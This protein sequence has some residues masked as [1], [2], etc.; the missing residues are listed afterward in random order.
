LPEEEAIKYFR[1]LLSAVGYC[2]Q[3]NI[4][5]RDLKPENI[6]LTKDYDVK[7]ADFGMA[8][9]QQTPDHRLQT[10][11][12]SPHYAAPEVIKGVAY[13][14]DKIDTWSMGV[15]LYAS[16]S[17]HLP[18]DNPDLAKLLATIQKGYYRMDSAFGP[19]ATDLIRRILQVDP[20]DRLNI[21]Q[22]W[23]HPLIRKY[24]HL[25]NFGGGIILKSPTVR[26]CGR[27]VIR[28]SDINMELLRHMRSLWH[29]FEE[30]DIIKLL[31]DDK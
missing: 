17:G 12:G 3:F 26:D 14:G 2:H 23:R 1:Q 25:D 4:C 15:I 13:K 8:A 5:H 21:N 18:F 24:D 10:S 11:C 6:L 31:L 29:H 28:K 27:P 9:L 20:R 7:I 22:I 16:L 30:K 19:E